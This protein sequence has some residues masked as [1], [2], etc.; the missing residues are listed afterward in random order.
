MREGVVAER[1]MLGLKIKIKVEI[2]VTSHL[3][4]LLLHP[5]QERSVSRRL[6]IGDIWGKPI[7]KCTELGKNISRTEINKKHSIQAHIC[8]EDCCI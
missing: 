2:D 7:K 5:V 8:V 3:N 4:G 6:G 1:G